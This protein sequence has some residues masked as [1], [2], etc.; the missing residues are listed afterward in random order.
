MRSQM[1]RRSDPRLLALPI[2][3]ALMVAGLGLRVL[4]LRT[5]SLHVDEF[6]SLL[7]IQ[8]ILQHGYPLLP[9]GTLY[10]QGL[11]FSYVEA[12]LLR[13]FGFEATA[14]RMFSLAVS[15]VTIALVYYVGS[16]MLSR[17]VGLLAAALSAFS[18]EAIAWGA[19]VRMY[20]LL[21][22]LVLLSVWF[23][24][25]GATSPNGARYR[26]LG[27]LC[28]LG[29]LFTHPVS[30]LLFL[31]L[32]LGLLW[33]RGLRGMLRP[34]SIAEVLVPLVGILGTLMLKAL[35]QPGQLQAL[36]EARPYL[37]PSLN[38]VQGFRPLS[39]FFVSYP[40]WPLSLLAGA[41]LIWVAVS[42]VR[43]AVVGAWRD[44]EPEVLA[45]GYLYVVF[46]VTLLEMVFLVGPTWQDS[47]YLFMVE[48][49]LFLV[50]AWT[51]AAGLSVVW[52]RV[53]EVRPVVRWGALKPGLTN[54]VVT[55]LLVLGACLLLAP[56]AQAAATHQEWGYDL[57]FQYLSGQWRPGDTVLTIVPYGCELYLPRCDYYASGRAYEEYVLDE[58]GVLIDRWVGSKL[59]T[60][61]SELETIVKENP[62][63]WL[64]IDGWRLAARFD[65]DFVRTV[66]EQMKVAYEARGV[67][68]LLAEGYTALPEPEIK[69]SVGVTFGEQIDLA[70]YEL[71]SD[72]LLP[73]SNA[74][75]T[76][77]WSALHP[78]DREYTVFVHL[79]GLNGCVISQ[80]DY[81]PLKNL[82]PTYYWPVGEV[83]PDSHTLA[84]P[85]DAPSG[86]YR[87]EV[88]IYDSATKERLPAAPVEGGPV[89]DS[90]AVD[91][92]RLGEENTPEPTRIIDANLGDQVLLLGEGGG[93]LSVTPG[94]VLNLALYWQATQEMSEDY[95]VF[96]HLIG[97]DGRAIAQYDAQPLD[98]FYPTSRWDLGDV[99]VDE[100]SLPIDAGVPEGEYELVVGMYLL[101]T[102]E[103]LPLLDR[104][105]QV[106]GDWVSLGE[107]SVGSE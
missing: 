5:I 84:I 15:L 16:R 102:G 106:V 26:W 33:L 11:L 37:A 83:V 24:W 61:S 55:C 82:Y 36:A 74:E 32:I 9:S 8:G 96:V 86:W 10:E 107:V 51:L 13:L 20:A 6:I 62:R 39:P 92:V 76:L 29:A 48:P 99:V 46:V 25:K 73:G 60:S 38:V 12:V 75:L 79:R 94:Q 64:V 3:A 14:G 45:P 34:S 18:A 17:R 93:P 91:Y 40:R 7:A 1:P 50:S 68:V 70:A 58:D 43:A 30:V 52:R 105:G 90:V 56:S 42:A 101:S 77:L 81:P 85:S 65:L 49:L 104:A 80:D 71:S 21:Q 27:I 54:G 87:L 89:E 78:I 35:G 41:G 23:L 2:L 63:T 67:R 69:G 98:G 22:L 53:S 72:D 97:S 31:P 4:Y 47:R 28:Y 59:V 95:T 103:R 66:A 100:V 57:A 44:R 19:R 88:G